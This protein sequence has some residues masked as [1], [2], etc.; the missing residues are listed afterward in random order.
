MERALARGE[1]VA[2]IGEKGPPKLSR[3]VNDEVTAGESVAEDGTFGFQT[4]TLSVLELLADPG[5]DRYRLA[6]EFRH[7]RGDKPNSAVGVYVGW[8]ET[9]NPGGIALRRWV[10]FEF[11]D[12]WS[13]REL[14][15][16]VLAD[17]HGVIGNDYLAVH[18]PQR[19]Y[20]GTCS[21]PRSTP[22]KPANMNPN[23][24]RKIALD[25]NPDGITVSWLRPEGETT[26]LVVSMRDILTGEECHRHNL[27]ATYP[28]PAPVVPSWHPRRPVGVYAQNAAV[29][30]RNVVLTPLTNPNP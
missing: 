9:A 6:A 7:L 12:F 22:I 3:W 17:L 20:V 28:P 19:A 4:H 15:N 23:P 21:T 13:P 24:W 1:A 10:G 14:Q 18:T 27:E 8:A 25:V 26:V 5:H 11:S 16:Q 30:F 29:A 2:L